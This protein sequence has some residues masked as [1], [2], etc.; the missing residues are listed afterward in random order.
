MLKRY[1]NFPPLLRPNNI[2]L[3]AYSLFFV[4]A[5]ST[6]ADSTNCRLKILGWGWCGVWDSRKFQKAKLEFAVFTLY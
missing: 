6:S 3:Y 4:Y 1:Q 2:P 5:G